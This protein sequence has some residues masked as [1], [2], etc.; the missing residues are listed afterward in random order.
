MSAFAQPSTTRFIEPTVVRAV[1]Q[2][3]QPGID[4]LGI[5]DTAAHDHAPTLDCVDIEIESR[6][7][8]CQAISA[9]RWAEHRLREITFDPLPMGLGLG[10]QF[11]PTARIHRECQTLASDRILR[12]LMGLLVIPLLQPVL[13]HSQMGIRGLQ[14]PDRAPLGAICAMRSAVPMKCP[15]LWSRGS[16]ATMFLKGRS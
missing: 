2:F 5:R 8:R 12:Q 15:S 3:F 1:A 11:L 7:S 4:R 6:C 9:V 10:R 16:G 14:L 13:Q